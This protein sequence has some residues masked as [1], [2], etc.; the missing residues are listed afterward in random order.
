VGRSRIIPQRGR[1]RGLGLSAGASKGMGKRKAPAHDWENEEISDAL[2]AQRKKRNHAI[3]KKIS[4]TRRKEIG[5]KK[6]IR[7][8]RATGSPDKNQSNAAGS[9]QPLNSDRSG[10]S[11]VLEVIE[12]MWDSTTRGDPPSVLRRGGPRIICLSPI[13]IKVR[14]GRGL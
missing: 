6:G 7:H 13:K 2:R 14:T 3:S 4:G 11:L 10:G 5:G 9:R 1:K 12:I 8:E